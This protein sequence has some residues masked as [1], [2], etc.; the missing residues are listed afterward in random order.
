MAGLAVRVLGV[1][2]LLLSLYALHVEHESQRASEGGYDYR[3][4]CDISAIGASCSAVFSSEW[5]RIMSRLGIV[6][7]GS[8]LDLPNAAYGALYY[9]VVLTHDRLPGGEGLLLVATL[10]S[11]ATTALLAYA[12]AFILGDLCVVCMSTYVVNAS[13]LVIVLR[14]A[15][16]G[17]KRKAA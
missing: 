13:L 16:T 9:V 17:A 15:L 6:P 4:L 1:L 8:A 14:A 2:G 11:S 3:A 5:G 7:A 12:L 10:L